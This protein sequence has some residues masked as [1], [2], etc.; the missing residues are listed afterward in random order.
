MQHYF[1]LVKDEQVYLSQDD[2]FHLTRVMRAKVGEE[3]IAVS[4]GKEYLAE[5]I[6]F[7]PLLIKVKEEL[8]NHTE[9]SIPVTLFF[10][11][12]KG[13]KIDLVI[14]KATELGVSKIVL[15]KTAR[16]VVKLSQTDFERKLP[17]YQAIAKEASE[18]SR[19]QVIPSI[20]GVVDIN[21]IPGDLLAEE[22]YVAYEKEAGNAITF[23]VNN[24][25]SVSVLIGSEGGISE[26]E[27]DSLLAQGFKTTSLGKRILRTETAALYSLSVLGYLLER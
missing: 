7:S 18:Q 19:R 24:A 3:I 1:A 6:S 20:V 27:F 15:V 13:D 9:L 26:K 25:K 10:A 21:A 23:N 16:D 17:R 14:Q 12:A 8:D 5:V 4:D 11:L 22:N 2:V